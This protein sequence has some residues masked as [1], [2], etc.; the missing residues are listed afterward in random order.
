MVGERTPSSPTPTRASSFIRRA[1]S[2]R[3]EIVG[4]AAGPFASGIGTR[5]RDSDM[6]GRRPAGPEEGQLLELATPVPRGGG[7]HASSHGGG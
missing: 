7:E 5:P 3:R 6:L 2:Q 1:R 4:D